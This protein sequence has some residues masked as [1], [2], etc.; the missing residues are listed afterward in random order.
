MNLRPLRPERSALAKLRYIPKRRDSSSGQRVV[1]P[2]ERLR[3]S[4]ARRRLSLPRPPRLIESRHAT[5]EE[6]RQDLTALKYVNDLYDL[7][8]HLP[9]NARRVQR[10][11]VERLDV[12]EDFDL[13]LQKC[14][15]VPIPASIRNG[16]ARDPRS[17]DRSCGRLEG[18]L[19][20]RI[21]GRNA[22]SSAKLR[23]RF[24]VLVATS[25]TMIGMI[26]QPTVM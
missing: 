4:P 1:N 2:L 5:F 3:N 11:P 26:L 10:I 9:S 6:T 12:Q 7:G 25:E 20:V 23:R 16:I 13:P 14:F 19:E 17:D 22:E 24:V 15:L 21:R 18:P 8:G